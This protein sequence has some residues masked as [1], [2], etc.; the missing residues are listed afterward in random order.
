MM[1]SACCIRLRFAF[2]HIQAAM[3]VGAVMEENTDLETAAHKGAEQ[4]L[5]GREAEHL[6]MD[7]FP[8]RLLRLIQHCTQHTTWKS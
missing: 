7:V 8:A 4:V 2:L 3:P 5:A 1:D 6:P